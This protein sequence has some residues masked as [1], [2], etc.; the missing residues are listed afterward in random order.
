[1]TGVA[2]G[3][4]LQGAD[5]PVVFEGMVQEMRRSDSGTCG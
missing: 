1:M 5:D 4:V 2:S 3:V